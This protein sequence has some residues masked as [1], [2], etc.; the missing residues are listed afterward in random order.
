MLDY[1]HTSMIIISRWRPHVTPPSISAILEGETTKL[2]QCRPAISLQ[3]IISAGSREKLTGMLTTVKI[4][5]IISV[6]GP[7][8]DGNEG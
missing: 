3:S 1:E 8:L 2:T 7:F 5:K 6:N 4:H